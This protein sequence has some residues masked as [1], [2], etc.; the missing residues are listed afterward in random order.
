[1]KNVARCPHCNAKMVEYKHSLNK[2]VVACLWKF[3]EEGGLMAF[4]DIHQS[5]TFNQASNFQKLK[6]WGLVEKV[7]DEEGTR[8]GGMWAI[9]TLGKNFLK[10]KTSV[11]KWVW[12][13]RN[14]VVKYGGDQLFITDLGYEPYREKIDYASD[15]VPRS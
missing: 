9:T 14:K 1:M 6:Y 10:N 5:F 2:N 11:F 12:T 8:L 7:E 15:A 3:L 13:Y 4:K